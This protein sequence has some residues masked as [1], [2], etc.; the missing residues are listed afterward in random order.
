MITYGSNDGLSVDSKRQGYKSSLWAAHRVAHAKQ[1]RGEGR[2]LEVLIAGGHGRQI[3]HRNRLRIDA[4]AE[5]QFLKGL[6]P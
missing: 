3:L 1:R 5:R 4:Q 2:H 6:F